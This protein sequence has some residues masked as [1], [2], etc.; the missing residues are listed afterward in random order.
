MP[1]FAQNLENT[2]HAALSNAADRSHEYATL[3][4]LLLALIDDTDAAEVMAACGVDL[5][6]LGDVVRQYLDQEYQSLKTEDKADP[7]PTAGFQRVIQRAI[8]HVQSSG[9]D[10]VT[11]ANVLVALFSERDSY[12]VYFLQQQDM[13][14][15]DAVSYIS[16]GIGKGG[17]QLENRAPGGAEEPSHN[18]EKTE[19]KAS[20]ASNKDSA[21]DQF[22]VNLNEKALNGKVDPLIGRGPEVDRTIQILCR[23]SKNNPLYVGDPGVGKTAIA[24]GLAR[25]IVEGEVPDVLSEAVIYSL[26]M[27]S[28]LAGTRYRGDFEERLKQV[29]SE[30]EKMP[31]AILF[32]DEIHTVIGAGATSGGAMDASNLLKPALSGGTIR[33]IGSTTYKEFRNHFEKDRALLRRFQK[34]DVN[35]P[36]IEDTIKILRGLRT[37]FE[38]HHKVKYTPD[39][40]K[41]AVE[42]SARYINDRK[43]PDKAIDVIDE[44]GAMQMLVPPS[45]RRKTITAREIEKVIATMARIPPKSVSSDDRKAL[46]HL[47]R[48]LKRVVYGQDKAIGVLSSA[49]KLSRAGLRDPDKP[50]GSFLFSGPTGVGKTE[51]ARQLANIMGIPLQRFDMSEYMERHSVSRLIGAPPGYVGYDQGG[52]LTD[53]VDQQ[54]HCV[55]LLDEIEKAHPDLFNILLQV[56]DNGRLTDHHGKTVDFRNVVLIMTTNAG[57]SDMARQG[58]GFGDVSKEDAGDEAVKLMFTPEFR[59]RLDAIV[60]FAYLGQETVSRVVDKFILQ[61]EL[62]LADQNVHIQFDTDARK[63][64]AQRGYDKLYGARPMARLIQEKVKQPLAEELLF[65]KL[66]QGGEVHVSVKDDKLNFELAPAAPRVVKEKPKRGKKGAAASEKNG[67]SESQD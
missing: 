4:H 38:E 40:I 44:V 64:L 43:L 39:A 52:L 41:T 30:L 9:K 1:S 63:W 3:E 5:S 28:L 27:G 59:N 61:L 10:T 11:G 18:E 48:D 56:M 53:A 37:A 19:T 13:S 36:T 57:A 21:L 14:R 31:H 32:I 50:I 65:G 55:L 54:P 25:K 8:L 35:E 49:M 22:C 60:P 26:D 16:H 62:Q 42:L 2:L 7:Q 15:L 17:R 58:I 34:I 29:V 47:E 12:A 20:G 23:R 51:V 24:E 6:D 33:C 45:R 67:E 46:E 66:S